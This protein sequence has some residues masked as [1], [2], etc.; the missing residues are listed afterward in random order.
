MLKEV[1]RPIPTLQLY[2]ALY[3]MLHRAIGLMNP[4]YPTILAYRPGGEQYV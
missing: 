4:R 2:E 3:A 1:L